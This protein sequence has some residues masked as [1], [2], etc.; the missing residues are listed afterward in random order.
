MLL[1]T[2]KAAME[3]PSPVSGVLSEIVKQKGEM[4][5]VGDVL[6]YL[7]DT[8]LPEVPTAEPTTHPAAATP[9]VMPAARRLMAERGVAAGQ[10]T[11]TGPGGRLLKED[12]L[13]HLDEAREPQPTA[14]AAA[15]YSIENRS[16]VPRRPSISTSSRTWRS[17]TTA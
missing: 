9:R 5:K 15:H 8:P 7:E 3:L 14:A 2:D 1:E 13:R 10:V 6:A 4:A 17:W 16:Y 11:P 12:V